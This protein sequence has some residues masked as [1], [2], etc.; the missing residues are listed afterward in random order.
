MAQE[1]PDVKINEFVTDFEITEGVGPLSAAELKRIVALV[2][3]HVRNEQYRSEQ[4]S[5]DTQINDRV[6]QPNARIF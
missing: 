4:R 3:E 5:R 2:L 6:F 1:S